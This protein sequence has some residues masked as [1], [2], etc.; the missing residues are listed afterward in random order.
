MD[1]EVTA[2]LVG[3]LIAGKADFFSDLRDA[4]TGIPTVCFVVKTCAEVQIQPAFLVAHTLQQRVVVLGGVE[5]RLIQLLTQQLGLHTNAE[6]AGGDFQLERISQF[7]AHI[8]E[9]TDFVLD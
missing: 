9:I 4:D 7:N 2:H 6:G 8:I 1:I 5:M 3:F